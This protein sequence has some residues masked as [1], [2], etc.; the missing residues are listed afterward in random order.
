MDSHFLQLS[1]K[2]MVT[3]TSLLRYGAAPDIFHAQTTANR[4]YVRRLLYK[5]TFNTKLKRRAFRFAKNNFDSIRFDSRQKID[6]IRFVR[7]DSTVRPTFS[8]TLIVVL[9]QQRY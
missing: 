1:L 5:L 2:R 9:Q 4:F 8:Y 3:L 6:S 7:F